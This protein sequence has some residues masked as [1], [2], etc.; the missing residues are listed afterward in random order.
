MNHRLVM[1][2]L[3]ATAQAAV[4]QPVITSNPQSHDNCADSCTFLRVAAVGTGL[5]YQWQADHGSGFAD[6]PGAS[7][8]DDT[9]HIC[10]TALAA[11]YT[12][13]YRCIVRDINMD[14]AVSGVATIT[15]DSCLPPVAD[16][17]YAIA[18]TQVCFTNTSLRAD[19]SLWNFGNGGQSILTDPCHDYG[20]L[21]LFY[22]HLYVFNDYGQDEIEKAVDLLSIEELTSH[23]RLYPN[24][25]SDKLYIASETNID[26]VSLWDMHG[27]KVQSHSN[28]RLT[29]EV[30]MT[31]LP[32]GVYTLVITT[33]NQQFFHKTIKQ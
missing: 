9:L 19:A 27:N 11:P 5:T 2:L 24:P 8:Q 26:E 25:V 12:T 4:A 16:F 13:Q 14:S 10:D 23:F 6:H 17:E 30:D 3:V 33:G 18:G 20:D 21:Q 32:K 31:T 15:T 28:N 29:G 1:L 7:A 22:V